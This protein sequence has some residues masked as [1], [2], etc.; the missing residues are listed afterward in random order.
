MRNPFIRFWRGVQGLAAVEFAFVLPIILSMLLGLVEL[1]HASGVRTQVINMASTAADLIAQKSAA[2]GSDID[3]SFAATKAILFPNDTTVATVT[4]TSV[5]DAGTGKTPIIAWSCSTTGTTPFAKGANPSPSL[6]ASFTAKDGAVEPGKGG[7]VIWS[8]VTYKYKSFLT[9]FLPAT[10]N[11]T[12]DFYAK[13]RRVLQV[14]YTS[15]P[16]AAAGTCKF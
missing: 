16:A 14:P 15:S 7:S 6:P 4:I 10:S 9:Y 8:R 3:T 11:W 13:P 5:I 1:S 12:N 2:T